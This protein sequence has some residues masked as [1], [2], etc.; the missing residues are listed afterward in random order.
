MDEGKV[1]ERY[2]Y[3]RA[4]AGRSTGDQKSC[5]IEKN[6]CWAYLIFLMF[7][8]IMFVGGKMC[9]MKLWERA[10]RMGL[11]RKRGFWQGDV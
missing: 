1:T 3:P 9:A 10:E 11:V 4:L 7:Q 8:R 6:S 5:S 2:V